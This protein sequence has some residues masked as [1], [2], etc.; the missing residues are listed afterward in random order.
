[1]ISMAINLI[2]DTWQTGPLNEIVLIGAVVAALG[3]IVKM[4]LLPILR[5]MRRLLMAV[6]TA[7]DRLATV[8]EHDDRLDTME[9][10]ICEILD[11]LRPTNG[12][13][14]SISDRLDTV[15]Q[16]TLTNAQEIRELKARVD[17]ALGGETS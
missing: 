5:W 3:A 15:K 9:R 4:V 1:M 2:P 14:R 6:E 8:P 7:S 17:L 16:Q 13:R 10:Q 12:D 11:A